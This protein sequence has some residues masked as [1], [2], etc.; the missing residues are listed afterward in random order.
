ML[1][2]DGGVV[3]SHNHYNLTNT[4]SARAFMDVDL[5]IGSDCCWT[6][7]TG[8]IR[9]GGVGPVVSRTDF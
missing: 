2:F 1:H 9:M 7:V 3:L 5:L 6:I 8:E 4:F